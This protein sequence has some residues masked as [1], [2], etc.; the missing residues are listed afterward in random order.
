[1]ASVS[2][3]NIPFAFRV[4]PPRVRLFEVEAVQCTTSEE[5]PDRVLRDPPRCVP[6]IFKSLGMFCAV[7]CGVEIGIAGIIFDY[8]PDAGAFWTV[9]A[10]FIAGT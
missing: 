6:S 10:G 2:T 3:R 8:T 4:N 1:M 5:A 7:F 9:I